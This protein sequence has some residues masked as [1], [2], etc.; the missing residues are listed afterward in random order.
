MLNPCI[1]YLS[2]S[3]LQHWTGISIVLPGKDK[4]VFSDM[5]QG[6]NAIRHLTLDKGTYK[7]YVTHP[8]SDDACV[9]EVT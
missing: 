6:K 5:R 7:W 3:F 4:S 8:S 1:F 2:L 9:Y